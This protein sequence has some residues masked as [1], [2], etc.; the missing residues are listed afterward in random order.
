MDSVFIRLDV[1]SYFT[2]PGSAY[3]NNPLTWG[4][5]SARWTNRTTDENHYHDH[6]CWPFVSH[7][8][9]DCYDSEPCVT[10]GD[11]WLQFTQS[12]ASVIVAEPV[13]VSHLMCFRILTATI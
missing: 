6:G 11:E 13:V 9:D 5:A 10:G 12:P 2:N 4:Q 1:A 7:P 3:D 8:N